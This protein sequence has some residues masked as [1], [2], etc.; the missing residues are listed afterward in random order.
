MNQARLTELAS[1]T[2]EAFT[3]EDLA[4]IVS[5]VCERGTGTA[6]EMLYS[7]L[8]LECTKAAREGLNPY[9]AFQR[10]SEAY[11]KIVCTP[12]QF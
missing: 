1:K 12:R 4:E 11:V 3:L 10:G 9:Q 6:S 8:M 2:E 7:L 5:L